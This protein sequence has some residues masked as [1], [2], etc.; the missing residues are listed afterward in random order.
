M[1]AFEILVNG[2]SVYTIGIGDRGMLTADVQWVHVDRK[3]GST[4][5]EF[6]L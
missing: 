1:V 3:A 4:Y 5:E 6:W 2:E